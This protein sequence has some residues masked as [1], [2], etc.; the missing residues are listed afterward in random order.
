MK[1]QILKTFYVLLFAL[2]STVAI[3]QVAI[4]ELPASGM[5]DGVIFQLE[6]PDKG[7]LIPR[8]QLLNTSDTTTIDPGNVE[9]LWVYNIAPS[10]S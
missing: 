5:E 4:G 2:F 7:L 3:G 1:L 6:S 8:V 10:G 9:G